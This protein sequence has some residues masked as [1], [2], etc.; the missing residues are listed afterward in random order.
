MGENDSV[1]GQLFDFGAG[2]FK[3]IVDLEKSEIELKTAQQQRKAEAAVI[4]RQAP[5]IPS[6]VGAQLQAFLPFILIGGVAL[7]VLPRL[8]KS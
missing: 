3:E 4:K 2:I 8:L 6:A 1:L 5:V 7:L